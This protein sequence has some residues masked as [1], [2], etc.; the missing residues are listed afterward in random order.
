M[1]AIRAQFLGLHFKRLLFL[2][3]RVSPYT[4][5]RFIYI[6]IYKY[7]YIH[8]YIY[9]YLYA[10]ETFH[11]QFVKEFQNAVFVGAF[12]SLWYLQ[13]V[14][15]QNPLIF[16]SFFLKSS[17]D[18]GC[19]THLSKKRSSSHDLSVSRVSATMEVSCFSSPIP[20]M[21]HSW[22]HLWGWS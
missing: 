5:G 12:W 21:V 15:W 13:V 18:S 9:N 3:L 4:F 11:Q 19:G 14:C 2:L 17:L 20:E 10:P 6:Y 7:I 8:I 16:F 1:A 22:L